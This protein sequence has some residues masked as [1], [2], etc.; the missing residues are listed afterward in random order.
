MELLFASRFGLEI[1]SADA[2]DAP[3]LA[4]LLQAAGLELSAAQAAARLERLRAQRS[5]VLLAVEWGPPSGVV[6]L[7]TR[8]TLQAELPEARIGL[9]LV[10]PDARRRGVGRLLLK[11]AAQAARNLGCG[12]LQ[13]AAPLEVQDLVDF[14]R[15]SGFENDGQDL[16]RPLR[17]RSPR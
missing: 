9:L 17:K 15:A 1:R 13:L 6:V 7:D 8:Q 3:G 11:A 4:E 5:T 10:A 14:A 2:A 16:S 12:R